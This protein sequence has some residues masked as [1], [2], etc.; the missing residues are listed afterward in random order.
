MGWNRVRYPA[1]VPSGA[2]IRATASL[3]SV[4]EKRDGWWELIDQFTIE[5]EGGERPVCVAE[6]V[7]R[8][9][10]NT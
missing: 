7:V 10:L 6:S 9:L 8:L 4:E 3:Q 5:V 2:R 1:P